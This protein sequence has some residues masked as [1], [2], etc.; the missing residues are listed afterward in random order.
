MIKWSTQQEAVKI[1]N[2]YVPS[3]T[4]SNIY[5]GTIGK[6]KRKNIEIQSNIWL[7]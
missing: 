7:F 2:L 5:I 4:I 1:L 3:N 6:T